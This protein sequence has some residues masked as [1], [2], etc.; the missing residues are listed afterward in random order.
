MNRDRVRLPWGALL[1]PP[2]V[3]HPFRVGA[4]FLTRGPRNVKQLSG[5]AGTY[6]I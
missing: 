6:K 3:E 1:F 5:R 2:L 4:P